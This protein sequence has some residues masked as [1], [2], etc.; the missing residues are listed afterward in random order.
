MRAD[1]EIVLKG[2]DKVNAKAKKDLDAVAAKLDRDSKAV[3]AKFDK[4]ME[5]MK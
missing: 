5:V 3:T 1:L 4:L 2:I